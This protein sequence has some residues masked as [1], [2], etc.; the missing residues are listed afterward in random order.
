MDVLKPILAVHLASKKPDHASGIGCSLHALYPVGEAEQPDRAVPAVPCPACRRRQ[1]LAVEPVEQFHQRLARRATLPRKARQRL[2]QSGTCVF[3]HLRIGRDGTHGRIIAVEQ[4]QQQAGHAIGSIAFA[5]QPFQLER[6]PSQEGEED[7]THAGFARD[8]QRM[9]TE[10]QQPL[11]AWQ[12]HAAISHA[13]RN[14]NDGGRKIGRM[15]YG[16]IERFLGHALRG[17]ECDA[18]FVGCHVARLIVQ[19]VI[20]KR[21]TE[22]SEGCEESDPVLR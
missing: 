10:A 12:R 2:Q 5:E 14:R 7:R 4:P 15:P 1:F 17:F 22:S 21:R 11:L 19:R 8:R 18:D 13:L 3:I 20:A 6:R 16:S 9:Q